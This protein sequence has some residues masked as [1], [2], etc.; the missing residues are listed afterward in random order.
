MNAKIGFYGK[1]VGEEGTPHLQGRQFF[2]KDF[3]RPT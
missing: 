1:E 3:L 2:N